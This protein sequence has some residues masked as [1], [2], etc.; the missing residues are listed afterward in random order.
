MVLPA[1]QNVSGL[2][3]AISGRYHVK[4]ANPRVETRDLRYTDSTSGDSSGQ[5]SSVWIRPIAAPVAPF[6]LDVT[7]ERQGKMTVPQHEGSTMDSARLCSEFGVLCLGFL[8][9]GEAGVGV[10]SLRCSRL[11]GVG[12]SHSQMGQRARPAVPDD[13]AVVENR[14]KLGGG[15]IAL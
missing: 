11:Q 7:V 9:D 15:G 13:A 10:R 2:S 3:K 1:T 8:Q 12:A 14:L 5:G 6:A 4:A